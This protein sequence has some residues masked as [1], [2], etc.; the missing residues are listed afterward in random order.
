MNA[1]KIK[2]I[3]ATHPGL[4]SSFMNYGDIIV[5]T[6]GDQ[7][8]NGQME[9]DY[10][11]DPIGTVKEIQKVLVKDFSSMEKDVNLLLQ[12]FSAEIGVENIDTPENKEKVREFMKNNDTLLQEIFK[13]GDEEIR[14]EVRELYILLR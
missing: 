1:E 2:T 10:V 12:R 13:K 6:E 3:N 5:L 7:G 9:M 4:F 14:Q 8:G 11:G